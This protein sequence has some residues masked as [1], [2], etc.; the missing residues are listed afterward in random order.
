MMSFTLIKFVRGCSVNQGADQAYSYEFI[1]HHLDGKIEQGFIKKG[2]ADTMYGVKLRMK[3]ESNHAVR[4]QGSWNW[5]I[6][7]EQRYNQL[8]REYRR[9]TCVC[10]VIELVRCG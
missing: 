10:P 8:L 5:E 3:D 9:A 4:Y 2:Q 7:S 1:R 6:I